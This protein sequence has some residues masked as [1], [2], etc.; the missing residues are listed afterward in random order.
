ME[1]ADV[2]ILGGGL[3]GLS[4][5]LALD[6]HGL[7][8]IVVDPADPETQIAPAYDGRATAVSSSSWH[9]LEAIGIAARLEGRTCPIRAIRVSDGLAPGGILFDAEQGEAPLGP[10]VENRLLR[11]ALRDAAR[12]AEHIR[13]LMPGRAAETV[14]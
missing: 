6:R 7:A 8:S 5:A 11:A 13:L 2:I 14:R 10:M 1:R 4:L 3:V 12:E 9:M